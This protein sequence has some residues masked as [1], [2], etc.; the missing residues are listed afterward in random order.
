MRTVKS[1]KE[2]LLIHELIFIFLV[3]VACSAGF[4]GIRVWDQSAQESYRIN[5]LIQEIQQTRGDLYRQ[6]KELFDAFFL[7]DFQAFDEYNDYTKKLDSHFLALEK[8]AQGAEE[9]KA[10]AEIKNSYASFISETTYIFR[11]SSQMNT[12]RVKKS[13]NSD[14]ETGVFARYENVSTRA[15][16]LLTLKQKEVQL[17]LDDAKTRSY[18]WLFIPILTALLLVLFSRY[19]LNRAI[20]RPIMHILR[21]TNEISAGNLSHQAPETGAKDLRTLSQAINQMA[22]DLQIS[23]ESLVKTEKQA[24]QGLLVPM[25]AHNIRNPLASIRATAQVADDK[26][27]PADTRESLRDI[28]STVDRLERWTGGLLAYLIP[29]KPQLNQTTIE[30]IIKGALSPLHLKIQ[31]KL[32]VLT[33]PNFIKL[34]TPILS[35]Q[36]LMEQMLYNLLSNAIDASPMRSTIG[37]DIAALDTDYIITITDAGCGMPFIPNPNYSSPGPSTKR[38]GTGL[39]I[40]FSYKVCEAL[41]GTIT[42]DANPS[43][44]TLIKIKLP[45]ILAIDTY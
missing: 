13:L 40:P 38:F 20:V 36:H 43:G 3:T 42:F 35:D 26:N 14:I 9:K 39:G 24:A 18:L 8:L 41:G 25:L 22:E 10:V 29:M 5:L 7:A 31:E 1:L 16:Q 21:A 19:F 33:L 28:M 17:K 6:M 45:K 32:I 27:L 23:Q 44:G 12:E 2:L 34:K 4:M 11:L 15:E 37:I 30:H